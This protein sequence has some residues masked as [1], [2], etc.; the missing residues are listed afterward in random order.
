MLTL[1]I[2]HLIKNYFSDEIG[3]A[4]TITISK[5]TLRM[6]RA[7]SLS[8]AMGSFYRSSMKPVTAFE[9]DLDVLLSEGF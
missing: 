8:A 7:S 5:L 6:Q 3:K 4:V 2:L 1:I 9:T